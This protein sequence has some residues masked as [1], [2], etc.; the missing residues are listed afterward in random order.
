MFFCVSFLPPQK[1]T[2]IE[3]IAK[4]ICEKLDLLIQDMNITLKL[5][6]LQDFI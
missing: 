3:N 6:V 5:F 4:C 2:Y 1:V